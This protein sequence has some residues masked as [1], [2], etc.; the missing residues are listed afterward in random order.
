MNFWHTANWPELDGR[1]LD[2]GRFSTPDGETMI[3]F[4]ASGVRSGHLGWLAAGEEVAGATAATAAARLLALAPAGYIFGGWYADRAEATAAV[5]AAVA[6]RGG[7]V[8]C[9]GGREAEGV[10]SI[11]APTSGGPGFDL[12]ESRVASQQAALVAY[13]E[14][15][16]G[17]AW[18]TPLGTEADCC[19]L[20][21][22]D[23]LW[24]REQTEK[25]NSWLVVDE[26]GAALGRLGDW[27]GHQVAD[28]RPDVLIIGDL[29]AGGQPLAAVLVRADLDGGEILVVGG[30]ASSLAVAWAM[31]EGG[32]VRAE[33]GMA[34]AMA[35]GKRL[36]ERLFD[37]QMRYPFFGDV[38]GAGLSWATEIGVPF[39]GADPYLAESIQM[40]AAEEGLWLG[41]GGEANH[42]LLWRPPL[43]SDAELIDEACDRFEAA[44]EELFED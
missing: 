15:E 10:V 40:G 8:L 21:A 43:F 12:E 14:H 38:R 11:P 37:W 3:D 19:P 32:L 5:A 27:W 33:M 41:R 16:I 39:R 42:V 17:A 28:I 24:W 4:T 30:E 18:L 2:N 1:Y 29:L 9:L 26:S 6:R 25:S 44:L 7:Q 20:V 22:D 31:V 13:E 23:W 35:G 36:A 34:A